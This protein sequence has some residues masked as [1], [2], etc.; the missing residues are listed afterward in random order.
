MSKIVFFDID[1]TL[2][3]HDKKLP[4]STKKAVRA[5]QDRGV[6]VA[7]ATG[8]SPF[9]FEDLRKE[10][11]IE[12][13]VSFNGQ[14]VVF[15]NEV[16]YKNPIRKESLNKL[17]EKAKKLQAPLVYMDENT[18]RSTIYSDDI[19]ETLATFA[20]P[21]P[22][23]DEH[24]FLEKD[25]YQTLLYCTPDSEK[26]FE[27]LDEHIRY[28]RWHPVCMDVA[29]AG[30]SKA[31]GI[32]KFLERAG[33]AIEDSYAFGDGLNDIEMLETVG[34]GI[35]MGNAVPELLKHADIVTTAVDEDG[36]YNG[37]LKA[38]LL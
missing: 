27:S 37:L 13:Y 5:L 30:G 7:I 2:L 16:I 23:L 4:E 38:K 25:I 24:Y 20:L 31:V 26:S 22:E 33:F 29:P 18:V 8:R 19:T 9:M 3:D 21:H 36:I 14:Y 17:R 32:L 34:T 15:E 11:N 1:G 6:Y 28:I 35:A 12:S 10:L